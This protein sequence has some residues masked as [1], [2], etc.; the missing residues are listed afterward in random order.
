MT[1]FQHIFDTITFS[2]S[3]GGN[4]EPISRSADTLMY[5]LDYESGLRLLAIIVEQV[6]N[7]WFGPRRELVLLIFNADNHATDA[8]PL[9]RDAMTFPKF[10]TDLEYAVR[11]VIKLIAMAQATADTLGGGQSLSYRMKPWNHGSK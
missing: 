1:K 2:W 5:S 3:N 6:R 10:P 11:L 7:G 8:A 9:M 4:L